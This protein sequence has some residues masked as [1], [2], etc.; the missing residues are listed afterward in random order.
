MK[1]K[2][3]EIKMS[4]DIFSLNN[5][6]SFIILYYFLIKRFLLFFIYKEFK[7]IISKAI[8]VKFLK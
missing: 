8:L 5:L 1:K 6:G 7:K 4:I 2:K 3:P